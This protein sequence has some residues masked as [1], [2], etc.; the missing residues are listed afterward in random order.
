MAASPYNDRGLR[1]YLQV[2][3]GV[4]IL[5][6]DTELELAARYRD[7]GDQSA[8]DTLI[9]AHLRSVVRI[10]RKF[11]GYGIPLSDL[12]AEGNI[13][14]L[15]AM[16]RFE[17]ERGLRFITYARYWIRATILALVLRQFSL[18]DMGT[19]AQQSKLFF[20][21]QAEK[22]RLE[23][24]LGEHANTN[25]LLAEEFGTSVEHIRHTL[26][27]LRAPD[28]SLDAPLVAGAQTTFLD[29]LADDHDDPEAATARR[30]TAELVRG[31]VERLWPDL[32]ARE[33]EILDAR[34][35]PRN[36]ESASL[37][38]LG[39]KMGVTRERVRQI[40]V[41]LKAKLRCEVR[42]LSGEMV[43]ATPCGEPCPCAAA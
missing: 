43:A 33:R 38:D 14:L 19:S 2:I 41:A 27:R 12:I 18:V 40:E 36:D 24:R 22:A 39:R 4:P 26:G 15:E 7:H 8:A 23:A 11:T 3:H 35:M 34:L 16:R 29:L 17:P 13:G 42:A 31:A 30:E 1:E 20:R 10:A 25:E 5:D 9:E 21:L 32:N 6:R 28:R 37:A